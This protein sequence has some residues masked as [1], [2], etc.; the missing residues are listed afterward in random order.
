MTIILPIGGLV[1]AGLII[2][3]GLY[4]RHEARSRKNLFS[5]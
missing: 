4:Q 3:Y 5:R 1:V 2:L